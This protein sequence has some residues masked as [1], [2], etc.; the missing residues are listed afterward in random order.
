M[1]QALSDSGVKPDLLVGTSAGALNAAFI[2][3]H[4]VGSDAL[5]E[6]A[7]AWARLRRRDVFPFD[8]RR[9]AAA[10]VGRAGSICSNV[11]L[12]RLIAGNL[13]Y[14]RLED[15][16]IPVHVVSTDVTTGREVLLSAGDAVDAVLASSAIP[17][18]FPSVRIDGRDLIDGGIADNAAVSQA[19]LL[20]ADVVYVLPTGYA[21]ALDHP[22]SSPLASA[23]QA[24]TLLIEQRLIL[25]VAR[26]SEAAHVRVIPPLCPL[27]VS[28]ADFRFG[29]MLTSR[30][31]ASSLRWIAE[32]GPDRAR[33]ERFLSLHGHGHTAPASNCPGGR[34]A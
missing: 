2:A 30:S 8:P 26:Y 17:A 11:Q 27:S 4:G 5:D 7:A 15:A 21:C 12:R 31:Y 13:P 16:A 20:G 6:L 22:P 14:R 23:L 1:L 10:A 19:V 24:L 33:P 18:V 9:L 25:E 32:G 29:A 3:G 28:S 34:A